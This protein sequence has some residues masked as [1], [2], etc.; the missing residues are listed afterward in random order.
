M[1]VGACHHCRGDFKIIGN[2]VVKKILPVTN[3]IIA[4][5]SGVLILLGYFFSRIFG[6]LQ[7]LLI[8]WAIILAAFALLLGVFNLA[9]VHWKKI[10]SEGPGSIY[11]I[12]LLISLA[13]TMVFA[14][15]SGPAGGLTLWVFNT[16]QVPIE[17]S[18]LAVLAI[19]LVYAVARLLS[20]RPKWNTILFV[21]TVLIVLLGSAPLFFIGEIA[22]LTAVR[23]WLAQVP[24]IA[25]A[26]GILLGVALGTVATGLRILIGVDRPYG[27]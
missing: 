1:G 18:L 14:G 7:S 21:V 6:D 20:R 5:I 3:A 27:G 19:I 9:I 4:I 2:L 13:V 10:G 26:R 23:T 22:P 16:F 15:I 25:G 8:G 17:I 11:S 24:A 12:V